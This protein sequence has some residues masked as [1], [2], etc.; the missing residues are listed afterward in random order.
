MK[1]T[2]PKLLRFGRAIKKVALLNLVLF[3]AVAGI[4]IYKA[5]NDE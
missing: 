3:G 2:T 4:T 5:F 1:E